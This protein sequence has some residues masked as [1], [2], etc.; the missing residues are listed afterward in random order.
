MIDCIA[1]L[2]LMMENDSA[3]SVKT[4]A[5]QVPI[6]V[7]LWSKLVRPWFMQHIKVTTNLPTVT[8]HVIMRGGGA[9]SFYW[10]ILKMHI[11]YAIGHYRDS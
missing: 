6:T 10:T 1:K 4:L 9:F 7:H 3:E 2:Q 11:F 5:M 8:N